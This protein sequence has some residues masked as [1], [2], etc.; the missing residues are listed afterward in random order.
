MN[1][2]AQPRSIAPHLAQDSLKTKQ[3]KDCLAVLPCT[4]FGPNK[5]GRGGIHNSCRA[6]M[7]QYNRLKRVSKYGFKPKYELIRNVA[8]HNAIVLDAALSTRMTIIGFQPKT[9]R[10]FKIVF[11]VGSLG[12]NAMAVFD[13]DGKL[14]HEWSYSGIDG[15]K[16]I[17]ALLKED[18]LRLE[19]S[20]AELFASKNVIY[21]L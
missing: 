10:E 15:K 6:C 17:L 12:M 20:Q 19:F 8:L 21:Y 11:N 16:H 4:D 13:L 18:G 9:K 14:F 2:D 7:A 3:C 1:K 5:L